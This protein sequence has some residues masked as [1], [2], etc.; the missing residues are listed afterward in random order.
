AN[1]KLDVSVAESAAGN[2]GDRIN[3][4]AQLIRKLLQIFADN[5]GTS[6]QHQIVLRNAA[7]FNWREL[8][9]DVREVDDLLLSATHGRQSVGDSRQLSQICRHAFGERGGCRNRI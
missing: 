4:G 9:I 1:Y 3:A 2:C 5:L 8:Y 6:P 7:L